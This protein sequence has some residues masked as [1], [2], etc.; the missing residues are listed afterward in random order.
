[1]EF[2]RLTMAQPRY[3]GDM[4]LIR[5]VRVREAMISYEQGLETALQQGRDVMTYFHEL[6]ESCK[7]LFDLTLSKRAM[8]FIQEN[9]R[10]MLRPIQ[11]FEALVPQGTYFSGDDLR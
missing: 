1:V 2:S 9:Y 10:T 11:V 6:E 5:D 4:R 8:E 3:S 7:P